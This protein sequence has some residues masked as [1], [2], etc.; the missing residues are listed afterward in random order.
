MT[1]A[2]TPPSEPQTQADSQQRMEDVLLQYVNTTLTVAA[3]K[4]IRDTALAI[5]AQAAQRSDAALRN[6]LDAHNESE[7]SG[8]RCSCRC[9]WVTRV[10][11][12]H[13]AWLDHFEQAVRAT[14]GY[15]TVA[16]AAASLGVSART[17]QQQAQ[18]GSLR[19]E[20]VGPRL[21]VTPGEVERYRSEN[22]GKHHGG[23]SSGPRKRKGAED[24]REQ[25]VRAALATGE[26]E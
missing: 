4:N 20:V 11:D 6:A 3:A 16:E 21:L 19:A 17:L 10:D 12:H 2:P 13:A 8:G 25:A 15:L 24:H 22:L 14:F 5:E 9:G 18:R 1:D 23:A 26:T 7:E